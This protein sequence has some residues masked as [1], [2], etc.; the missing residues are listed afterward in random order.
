VHEPDRVERFVLELGAALHRYGASSPRVE[1]ALQHLSQKFG[2][3]A[4]FFASPTMLLAAFGAGGERAR[5]VRLY[6][7]T[8]DLGRLSTLDGLLAQLLHCSMT[9]EDGAR[10]LETLLESPGRNRSRTI[11]AHSVAAATAGR[12]VGGGWP[13]VL[14]AGA[15]GCAAGVLA[16]ASR[17][18]PRLERLRVPLAA[19]VAAFAAGAAAPV[20]AINTPR[21]I[22]AGVIVLRPGLALIIAMTELATGHLTSG[23]SRFSGALFT[24]LTMAVGVALGSRCAEI[25][26]GQPANPLPMPLPRWTAALAL[27]VAPLATAALF[28]APRRELPW[29]VLGALASYAAGVLGQRGLGRE[30]GV[31]LGGFAAGAL[32][33]AYARMRH[34][35]AAIVYL[36]AL[37][38]LVPGALG[39]GSVTALLASDVAQGIDIAFTTLL[40][41]AALVTGMH[42]AAIIVPPRRVL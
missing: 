5:L 33:N 34:R 25:L 19:F 24:F 11:A 8:V 40:M 7:A 4:Q 9:L 10:Q 18:R 1:E 27:L 26:F 35:P 32:A 6:A 28:R 31:V 30:L 16:A 14:V 3:E 41:A 2:L 13:E 38:L 37:L 12:L 42:L 39:F 36:P 22:V 17:R 21:A 29:I 20:T 15:V 23:T